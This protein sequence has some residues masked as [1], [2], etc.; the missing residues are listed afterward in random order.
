MEFKGSKKSAITL[1]AVTGTDR[2]CYLAFDRTGVAVQNAC[3]E[4]TGD[5]NKIYLRTVWQK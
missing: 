5:E 2:T 1:R 3:Q 4:F